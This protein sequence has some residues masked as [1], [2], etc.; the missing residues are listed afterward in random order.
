MFPLGLDRFP[1]S[2]AGNRFVHG[3]TSLQEVV[4]PVIT[5]K[6]ERKDES[7]E[8]KA[9][10]LRVPEKITTARLK[11]S[12]FQDEPCEAK[13]FLPITLRIS[14]VPKANEKELLCEPVT[15]RLDST[16]VEPGKGSNWSTSSSP[17]PL[18][19]TTINYS[20]SELIGCW[21]VC[22]RRFASKLGR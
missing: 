7:R 13:R 20:S 9:E 15:L 19:A 1:R 22:K 21:R 5:L 2:G 10:L 4:V 11:F 14:V 18:V 3:G 17:M 16:A 12:L 6:K 8:V